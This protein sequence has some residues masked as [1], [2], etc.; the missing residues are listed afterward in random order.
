MPRQL[1]AYHQRIAAK[2]RAAILNAATGLFLQLGY[3][4][5]SLA[6]VAV[7]AGVSKATLFKQFPTK[8]ELFEATVLSA[9]D[10]PDSEPLEPPSGDFHSGLVDLGMAYAELLSRPHMADLI[11]AVIAE[12]ARFP[13]LRERTFNFGTLP[14]LQA[15]R[16]FFQAA[17]AQGAAKVSDL[18][19]AAAQFLGMIATVVFWP[20]LVHGNWS[21]THEE[22]LHTVDEAARTVTARYAI[23]DG[24]AAG[25]AQTAPAGRAAQ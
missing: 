23:P 13:E 2:N 17:N 5:T 1:S 10:T 20:R 12:S 9:G 22:I 3:D 7:D 24:L 15:L 18:D 16:Q 11:R 4:Q 14:V 19:V 8:A 21:L 6:R 25:P